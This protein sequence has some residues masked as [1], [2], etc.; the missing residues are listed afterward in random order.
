LDIASSRLVLAS[1]EYNDDQRSEEEGNIQCYIIQRASP[2]WQ[3]QLRVFTK[4]GPLGEELWF[5]SMHTTPSDTNGT[6]EMLYVKITSLSG[7]D[8]PKPQA[9]RRSSSLFNPR[10]TPPHSIPNTHPLARP[11]MVPLLVK[12]GDLVQAFRKLLYCYV[13]HCHL[14]EKMRGSDSALGYCRLDLSGCG[15]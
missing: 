13:Q 9:P 10:R 1:S 2:G 8:S 5:L 3:R 4:N 6:R 14:L 15:S 7:V 11:K 12:K